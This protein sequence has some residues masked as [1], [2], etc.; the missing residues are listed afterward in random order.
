MTKTIR[1]LLFLLLLVSG[2]NAASAAE[3]DFNSQIRPILSD[4]CFLC[5]GPSESAR[6]ADLR[7]DDRQ[8]AIDSGLLVPGEPD[9][10]EIIARVFAGDPDFDHASAGFEQ[11]FDRIAE[12]TLKAMGR[13]RRP[14]SKTL[15]RSCRRTRWWGVGGGNPID[16][17]IGKRLKAAGLAFSSQAD[18]RTFNPPGLTRFDRH[19]AKA[20]RKWKRFSAMQDLAAKRLHTKRLSISCLPLK[21]MANE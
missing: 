2:L 1:I 15:G 10:D 7:L 12:G 4:N 16:H 8:A 5:H 14:V 18:L 13:R 6:K 20:P 19:A 17:F 21:P 3:I 11:A 9:E